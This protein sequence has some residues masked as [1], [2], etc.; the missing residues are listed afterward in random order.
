MKRSVLGTFSKRAAG[1]LHDIP[2]TVVTRC[3]KVTR[4]LT[5]AFRNSPRSQRS[6]ST[7]A[8]PQKMALAKTLNPP[9]WN[10]GDTASPT[11]R[12]DRRKQ[13]AMVAAIATRMPW[14]WITALGMEVVP[15]V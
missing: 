6:S 10:I 8:P 11:S 4:S 7:T 15:D 12:H 3:M 1:A 14:E 2:T 5:K 9:V 13:L